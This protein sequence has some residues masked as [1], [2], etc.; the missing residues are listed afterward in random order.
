MPTRQRPPEGQ[1]ALAG[2]IARGLASHGEGLSSVPASVYVDPDRFSAEQDRIFDRLPQV[3]APSALLARPNVAVPH[4]GVGLPLLLT[5][6]QDGKAHVLVNV[7][8][9]RGTRLLEGEAPLC[10]PRLVCPYHSRSYRLDGGLA[11]LPRPDTFPGLDK[12]DHHLVELPSCEAG[13]LIWFA[14]GASDFADA[15]MLA[16][17][18]DAF[19]L[20]G[21][22]LYRRRV[23]A[24][25]SNWK[26]I[27][28]AFL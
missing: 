3:V 11:G 10:A 13:G 15:G 14:R 9:H 16:A 20:A 26:L 12:G 25:D 19:G 18:F 1:L 17:E 8:R 6:D 27:M 4:D 21:H 28:D 24:V 2:R 5:R 22:H 23:H 7:C